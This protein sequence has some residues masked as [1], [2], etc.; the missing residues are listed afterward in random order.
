VASLQ[1]YIA[2]SVKHWSQTYGVTIDPALVRAIIQKESSGGRVDTSVEPGGH[3]SYGPMM[4][5]DTTA[6]GMGVTDPARLKE[7]G[8]G[9]W[10]GVRY[11][12]EQLRRFGGEVQR[13]V[14][15]Y[16]GGPGIVAGR[17]AGSFPNQTYVNDVL[18][19]YRSFR[20]SALPV[21]GLVVLGGI[22]ILSARRRRA[23]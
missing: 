19:F 11:F 6:A 17:T 13:A 18:R 15:A 8:L 22:L 12:A 16:N 10:Y 4:V 9:I 23:A 5:L 20:G 1:T 7:P 2:N 14:A 3:R 21:L